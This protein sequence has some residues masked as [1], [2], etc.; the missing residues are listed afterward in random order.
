MEPEGQGTLIVALGT[1]RKT[2]SIVGTVDGSTTDSIW[3]PFYFKW[4]DNLSSAFLEQLILILL[5]GSFGMGLGLLLGTSIQ[6]ARICGVLALYLLGTAA[7]AMGITR[8]NVM[9][10]MKTED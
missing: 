10:L 9:Q 3:V 7:A 8:I 2:L 4:E 6:P 5:G 1:N